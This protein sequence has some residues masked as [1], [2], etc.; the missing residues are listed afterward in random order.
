MPVSFSLLIDNPAA[1]WCYRSEPESG[2]NNRHIPIPRGK[3]LGGSSAIN[4]L[5]YVRGQQLDY[6]T[7]AQLGNRGW[8]YADVLPFFK[9]M[10]SFDKGGTAWVADKNERG[11]VAAEEQPQQRPALLHEPQQ[12][13]HS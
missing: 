9:S 8:S 12:F 10:E 3:L 4:G 7:W 13:T 11:L 6:D 5:V 1:N 2:T